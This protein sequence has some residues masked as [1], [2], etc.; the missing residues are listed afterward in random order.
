M[1]KAKMRPKREVQT[2]SFGHDETESAMSTE[3]STSSARILFVGYRATLQYYLRNYSDVGSY[4]RQK[5]GN[6]HVPHT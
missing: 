2:N 3:F 6:H 1:R 5:G 4:A